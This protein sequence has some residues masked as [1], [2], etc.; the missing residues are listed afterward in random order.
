MSRK[1][2]WYVFCASL[3]ISG[4]TLAVWLLVSGLRQQVGRAEGL[5]YSIDAEG[6]VVDL[7]HVCGVQDT[8]R[9]IQRQ[10]DGFRER[11][12]RTNLNQAIPQE[13]R[14]QILEMSRQDPNEAILQAKEAICRAL[15]YGYTECP[16][17]ERQV[18]I[19]R[20]VPQGEISVPSSREEVMAD[21][22]LR[23]ITEERL[24]R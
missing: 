19:E 13:E 23:R 3:S 6:N 24:R 20:F 22:E 12:A 18:V 14:I 4:A 16:V 15:E 10:I 8:D 7:E 21:D 2:I 1:V 5:C 11:L 17:S 9:Q